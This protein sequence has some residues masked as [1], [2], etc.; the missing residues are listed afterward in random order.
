MPPDYHAHAVADSE[1]PIN[2][3]RMIPTIPDSLARHYR[4]NPLCHSSTRL[5][6]TA[7]PP[8]LT[9]PRL[10]VPPVAPELGNRVI[11]PVPFARLASH[12][13]PSYRES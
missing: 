12:G 8:T 5:S 11:L 10:H 2:V 3:A 13:R 1:G 9:S 7:C 4:P 6:R